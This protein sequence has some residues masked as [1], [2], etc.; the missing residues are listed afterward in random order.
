MHDKQSSL[1]YVLITP[2]RNEEASIEKTIQ[3]VINQT[4]M[5]EK[6]VIVSDGST[7]R[8]DEI[9][10]SYQQKYDFIHMVRREVDAN[11]DFASKV[12]AI[13]AGLEKLNGTRYDFIG[14]LD[15]DVS[16]EQDFY[17]RVFKEFEKNPDLGI[18]G[19]VF[20]ELNDGQ[21]VAQHTNINWSVGGCTQ[22][23][24]RQ[25]YEDS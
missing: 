17:E 9:V 25:C 5:P 7:D 1:T 6:W 23:F 15:A 22:T 4:V 10:E 8:T 14:N 11:R 21:W 3:S 24:R 12:Y 18:C 13:R 16:F 2:A 20:Y 19:G